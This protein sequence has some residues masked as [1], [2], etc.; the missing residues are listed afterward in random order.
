MFDYLL[1]IP[2][3]L[4]NR[5]FWNVLKTNYFNKKSI[6]KEIKYKFH[7]HGIDELIEE[8]EKESFAYKDKTYFY[9]NKNKLVIYWKYDSIFVKNILYLEFYYS[10]TQNNKIT[11]W[12]NEDLRSKK[13]YE[14]FRKISCQIEEIESR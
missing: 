5:R 7:V 2:F 3:L 12:I 1:A 10:D 9:D 14:G 11:I 6:D 13:I 4:F 8:F